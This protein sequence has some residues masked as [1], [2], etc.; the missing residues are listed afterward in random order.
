LTPAAAEAEAALDAEAAADTGT[1]DLGTMSEGAAAGLAEFVGDL[2]SSGA[3]AT[4]IAA[5]GAVAAVG[6]LVIPSTG[7]KGEWVKVGDSGVSYF[8]QPDDTA[9]RFRYTDADG[10]QQTTSASPGPD[11]NY[12][13]PNGDVIAKW[14][15]TATGLSL[16]V[17]SATLTGDSDDPKL[18]PAATP[19]K[20]GA[21][22]NNRDYEDYVKAI[23]NPESPTPRALA[24]QFIDPDTGSAVNIDD[25]HQA[26]GT[27]VEIK[28]PGFAE[29]LEPIDPV[30]IGMTSRFL[31]Q[32]LSQARASQGR[33]L[34]W[35]FEEQSAADY[36][37]DLFNRTDKGREKIVVECIP[38]IKK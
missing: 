32:S 20:F 3:L 37:R 36:A 1:I 19:D 12:R 4:A 6:I 34:I 30:G 11:G 27:P 24:Y 17:S 25:C 2:V 26:S 14:V 16:L 18:C 8:L 31:K 21:R 38:W 35:V 10:Q 29:H 23:I 28:G 33:G 9:V 22:D 13:D 7:P 15:R 5:S